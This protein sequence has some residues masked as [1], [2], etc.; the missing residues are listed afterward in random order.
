MPR[1]Q[2]PAFDHAPIAML[3]AVFVAG[4]IA[5]KHSVGGQSITSAQGCG[6]GSLHLRI[7]KTRALAFN[8]LRH[9]TA[10]RKSKSPSNMKFRL[11]QAAKEARLRLPSAPVSVS[12]L[13]M[14]RRGWAQRTD[15]P[16]SRRFHSWQVRNFIVKSETV[17]F[18]MRYLLTRS[19]MLG[20]MVSA[21]A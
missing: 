21:Y 4:V 1:A 11:S 5:Q 17:R 3:L 9:A 15:L 14:R 10:E 2:T 8:D 16:L 13:R 20:W 12:A 18:F 6:R 7:W 19:L